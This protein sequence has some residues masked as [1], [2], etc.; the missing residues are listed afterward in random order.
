MRHRRSVWRGGVLAGSLVLA[1]CSNL[2][3]LPTPA[4]TPVAA[5]ERSTG[6]AS[7]GASQTASATGVTYRLEIGAPEA[8]AR[9]LR[10]H[11]DLARFQQATAADAITA[12]E[13]DRLVAAS[14]AQARDLLRTE[15]YFTAVVTARREVPAAGD[16]T[17]PLVMLKV[18]P[19]PRA[20]VGA[21]ALRAQGSLEA[22]REG[23]DPRATRIWNETVQAWPLVTG[24][25]FTQ[26]GWDDAK[27]ALLARLRAIGYPQASISG[28]VARVD[29]ATQQV[30]LFAV[31][32]SGPLA[33]LGL[34]EVQG[35]ERYP[36]NSVLNVVDHTPGDPYTEKR[37]L[38]LQERLS[39]VG[40]FDGVTVE[41]DTDPMKAL[42]APVL[43]TVRE[44][45]LQQATLGAGIS[46][47]TGPRV[48]LEHTHR[49]PFGWDWIVRNKLQVGR[50]ERSW[51][52]SAISHP[53]RRQYRAL[54]SGK[55]DWLDAGGAI[56]SARQVRV[57]GSLDTERIERLFF[58][59]A[60]DDEL[61]NAAGTQSA[62]AVS[63]NYHLVWRDLDNVVLPTFG[64]TAN[65]QAGLGYALSNSRQVDLTRVGEPEAN[66]TGPYARAYGRFT[67]YR[68]FARH[69]Y[70][71]GRLEVGQIFAADTVQ[72]P[73]T[74]RF[75]AG[76]DESVRGYAYRTLGPVTNG[77][78]GSGRVI[79]TISAEVARP[80]LESLPSVWGAAFIDAGTA[81][82][83][84]S[85][86]RPVVG[87]G[88]GARWRSPVGP[89]RVDLAYGD[90][91]RRARLHVS[92]GIVF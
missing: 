52:G 85:D 76:G 27:T 86:Y 69:W 87:Y 90:A 41:L 11:L 54:V 81:A 89:L 51:E 75:R 60:L 92:V 57:G 66:R 23:Q 35:L 15:G 16:T 19:G 36:A 82:D 83:R 61:R 44:A 72:L 30:R 49:R 31:V 45:P 33:R 1:G 65:M 40:L 6:P 64:E 4:A 2:Q 74:L 56:T 24:Q 7:A 21:W 39:K 73:E 53:L 50:D 55:V 10:T 9:L 47:N 59:E 14:E 28:S 67:L 5:D 34:A 43:I 77:V 70:F 63:A 71:T 13:L 12:S 62:T 25:D 3:I 79:G 26:A 80:V 78:I 58:L 68:P 22:D 88:V 91:L 29:T 42:A 20:R 18:E 48:S 17:P 8:L 37:L 38:D 32:D 84:W 46:A